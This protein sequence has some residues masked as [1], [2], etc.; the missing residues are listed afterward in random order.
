MTSSLKLLARRPDPLLVINRENFDLIVM[1]CRLGD[2]RDFSC[3]QL[4]KIKSHQSDNEIASDL[5]LYEVFGDRFADYVAAQTTQPHRS[6]FHAA[7]HEV[8][9]WYQRHIRLLTDVRV[10]LLEAH[11]RRYDAY[12]RRQAVSDG[13]AGQRGVN[14]SLRFSLESLVQ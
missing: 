8:A 5:A 10:F 7:A 14:F 12:E 6:P 3:Y 1:L 4:V 2:T 11:K 9:N 13:S